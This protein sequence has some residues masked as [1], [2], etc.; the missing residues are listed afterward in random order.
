MGARIAPSLPQFGLEGGDVEVDG[1]VGGVQLGEGLVQKLGNGPVA[2]PLAVGR[3]DVPGGVFGGAAL[4]GDLVR[5]HVLRPELPLLEVRRVELPVLGGVLQ[6]GPQA[7]A[8]LLLGDVQETLDD[9]DALGREL[10]LEAVDLVVP[11]APLLRRHQVVHPDDQHILVV[12]AVED[13]EVA[14]GRHLAADPPQEV[15]P[16]LLGRRRLEGLDVAALRVEHPDD[17]LDGAVLAA[18]IHALQDQQHPAGAVA[19]GALGVQR[20]LQRREPLAVLERCG[21]RPALPTGCTGGGGRVHRAEVDVTALHPEDVSK[22][23]GLAA[24]DRQLSHAYRRTPRRALMVSFAVWAPA[25]NRVRL[26][27]RSTGHAQSGLDDD[28]PMHDGAGGWW[29]LQVPGAGYGTDYGFLLDDDET[30]LPDPRSRWQP[31]GVHGPSRLYDQHAHDWKDAGWTGR[32]LAGSA[33]YELHIGTFTQEGT[34]D[35]AIE[36]LDHLVQVGVD[37]VEVLPV[38]AFN[39]THNW[40]YDGV[41]WYAVHEPYGGPD[42]FKRFVDACHGRGLGV[43]LDVVYNHLGPSGNYLPRFG[44]YLKTGRNTWGDLV[45]LDG[46]DSTEVRRYII[47]NALM[48]L[49]DYHVDG[50]RLDAVHAL[51]DLSAVHLLEQLAAEVEAAATH[52]G[53]PLSLV[54]ESDLNDPKLITARDGGGY[55]LTGQWDDDVHHALAVLHQ[56]RRAGAVRRGRRRPPGGVRRARLGRRRRPRPAGPGHLRPVEAGLVRAG[57]GLAPRDVRLLLQADRAAQSPPGAVRPVAD[58]P[59]GPLRG[60]GRPPVRRGAPRPVRGH[61]QPVR[62]PTPHPAGRHPAERAAG[63]RRRVRL[64]RRGDRAAGRVDRRGGAGQPRL[65]SS[66]VVQRWC[67]SGRAFVGGLF[68]P[69]GGGCS[70]TPCPGTCSTAAQIREPVPPPI[71]GGRTG[72][73]G[74]GRRSRTCGTRAGSFLLVLSLRIAEAGK[75]GGGPR[76]ALRGWA[77]G[78]SAARNARSRHNGDAAFPARR[79]RCGNGPPTRTPIPP[80]RKIRAAT[81]GAILTVSI[82]ARWRRVARSSIGMAPSLVDLDWAPTA[83]SQHVTTDMQDLHIR[84]EAGGGA[85]YP[86]VRAPELRST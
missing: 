70:P 55:G 56:P 79:P 34:F 7:A 85:A 10:A 60:V 20:L 43:V 9:G 37:L 24:H 59:G 77:L 8:L 63:Q 4:Q 18:G 69:P 78:A 84:G 33:I 26:R 31:E 41:C 38:N 58:G 42:G 40:G 86:G 81:S 62:R 47:D 73:D 50:L 75:D 74:Q 21:D 83:A 14:G 5:L 25:A 6:A 66:C 19:G 76:P 65:I 54:A 67:P 49:T 3:D 71:H 82:G 64:P 12:R 45:N 1:W 32:Q 39:G 11:L 28:Q 2:V 17:V 53:R 68:P 15:V 13:A 51:V 30:L 57:R 46:P 36:R 35:A 80:H 52:L 16:A 44:P 72:G 48:W 23:F 29:R 22:G 27:L 61:L